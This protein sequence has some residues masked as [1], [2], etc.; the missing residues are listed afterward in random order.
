MNWCVNLDQIRNRSWHS[1]AGC[2]L[3]TITSDQF[4][5]HQCS[6][7]L[8]ELAARPEV[9]VLEVVL[10][11]MFANASSVSGNCGGVAGVFAGV[12]IDTLN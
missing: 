11:D 9:S 6:N 10:V 5:R 8:L 3:F 4:T 12:T 2:P 1:G 7:Q